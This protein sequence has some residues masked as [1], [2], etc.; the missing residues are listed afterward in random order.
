MVINFK[1]LRF[2]YIFYG[3]LLRKLRCLLPSDIAIVHLIIQI[4]IIAPMD[5]K[6]HL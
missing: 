3:N 2:D 6:K 4:S 1:Y 5:Q